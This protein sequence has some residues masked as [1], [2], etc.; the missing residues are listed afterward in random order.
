V[1]LGCLSGVE[2]DL[3]GLYAVVPPD[4]HR[5]RRGG[6]DVQQ[7]RERGRLGG[8]RDL[9]RQG[10]RLEVVVVVVVARAIRLARAPQE[11]N[12]QVGLRSPP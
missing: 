8:D 7:A 4:L 2:R 12:E 6:V 3:A 9:R 5:D 10:E 1:V 11:P